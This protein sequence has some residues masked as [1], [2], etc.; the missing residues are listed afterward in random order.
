MT[1]GARSFFSK[2]LDAVGAEPEERYKSLERGLCETLA[3]GR[4]FGK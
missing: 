3:V 4:T 2:V 1:A